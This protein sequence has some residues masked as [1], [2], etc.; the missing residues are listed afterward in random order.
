MKQL[1]YIGEASDY[2]VYQNKDGFLEG[3]KSKGRMRKDETYAD[4]ERVVTNEKTLAGFEKFIRGRK[5]RPE[6]RLDKSKLPKL[7][8]ELED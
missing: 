3:Y 2:Q 1:E 7:F 4:C 6:K 8:N 5:R